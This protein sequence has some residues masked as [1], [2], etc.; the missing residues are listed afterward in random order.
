V[1]A[2]MQAEATQRE[3]EALRG[4]SRAGDAHAARKTDPIRLSRVWIEELL[5]LE[6]CN[7]HLPELAAVRSDG[8]RPPVLSSFDREHL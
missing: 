4:V 7:G 2:C 1:S 5:C 6:S 3:P 8:E